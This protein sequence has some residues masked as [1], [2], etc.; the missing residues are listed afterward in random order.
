MAVNRLIRR[1]P[2]VARSTK[3]GLEGRCRTLRHDIAASRL[4]RGS[5]LRVLLAGLDGRAMLPQSVEKLPL[6][7]VAPSV[8]GYTMR[9]LEFA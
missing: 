8:Q 1:V 2:T 5:W 7:R 9:G 6:D 4:K 3:V